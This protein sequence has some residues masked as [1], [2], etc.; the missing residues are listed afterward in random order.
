M[1]FLNILDTNY[2]ILKCCNVRETGSSSDC[3]KY[4]AAV[5]PR[6]VLRNWMAES[7][8][9]K[10]E[11]NDFSEVCIW[12]ITDILT[13]IKILTDLKPKQY[14]SILQ[15]FVFKLVSSMFCPLGGADAP[16]SFIPLCYTRDRRGG[17]LC[18]K[19]STVG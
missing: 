6:Y 10:T 12:S 5:N 7:A 1:Y 9:R 4:P 16:C 2:K 11:M 14:P 3:V 8:I 13:Y 17:G 15:L 18:S 19:T